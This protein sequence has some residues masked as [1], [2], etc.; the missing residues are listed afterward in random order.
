[1]LGSYKSIPS[2]FLFKIK[3]I[4]KKALT[5]WVQYGIIVMSA[6]VIQKN[7]PKRDCLQQGYCIT[8]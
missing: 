3:V 7:S 5:Y 2:I 8:P 4:S 6:R 1:M